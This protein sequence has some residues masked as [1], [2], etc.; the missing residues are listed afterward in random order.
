MMGFPWMAPLR[1]MNRMRQLIFLSLLGFGLAGSSLP[2]QTNDDRSLSPAVTPASDGS[3]TPAPTVQDREGLILSPSQVDEVVKDNVEASSDLRPRTKLP[4]E[5]RKKLIEFQ[6]FREQYL[7]EQEKLLR[8]FK[9][10]SE[11]DRDRIRELIRNRREAWLERSRAIKESARERLNE[12]SR[13][14]P[15]HREAFDAARENAREQLNDVRKRRAE[16]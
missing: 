4:P 9:G 10:A 11:A 6:R 8:E 13:E 3:V 1:T 14:L 2:G 12:L 5:V 7:R 15:K 16:D